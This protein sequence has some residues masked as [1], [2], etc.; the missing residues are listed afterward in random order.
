MIRS[1]KKI[2]G[3]EE[4]SDPELE[5]LFANHF[6]MFQIGSDIYL[7]IGNRPPCRTRDSPLGENRESAIGGSDGRIQC[8][9]AVRIAMSRD[10]FERLRAEGALEF[11]GEGVERS[12][13]CRLNDAGKTSLAGHRAFHSGRSTVPVSQRVPPTI[14]DSTAIEAL[15]YALVAGEDSRE[16][17]YHDPIVPSKPYTVAV[18]VR[19]SFSYDPKLLLGRS[20]RPSESGRSIAAKIDEVIADNDLYEVGEPKPNFLRQWPRPRT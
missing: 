7:D 1:E 9:A 8:S 17:P 19:A 6:E 10:S 15:L 14:F 5:P 20:V 11:I 3:H 2:I 13:D 12:T 18:P 4:G 16:W